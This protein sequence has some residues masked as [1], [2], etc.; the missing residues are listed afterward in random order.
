MKIAIIDY[1]MGNLRSVENAFVKLGAQVQIT[2]DS[3]KLLDADGVI[4]PGVGAIKEA[5]MALST[6]ALITPIRECIAMEKPFLGIC[7][8]MQL[9]FEKSYEDGIHGGLGILP[10]EIV[11]LD[12]PLKV[13]HI[14]WNTLQITKSS[15]LF[16]DIPEGS[17]MYFVHSYHLKTDADVISAYTDYGKDIPIA[18][19][20]NN[21]YGVQFHP[22]KSGDIGLHLLKNFLRKVGEYHAT[23]SS[24]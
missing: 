2:D 5:M 19:Q 10:G 22:E 16:E 7:L 11:K 14:G 13:P 3:Q 18:A 15:P 12:V 1:G 6:K 4:L 20:S 23:L 21:V 8:G 24:N 9:L 17:M